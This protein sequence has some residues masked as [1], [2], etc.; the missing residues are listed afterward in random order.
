[1]LPAPSPQ[2]AKPPSTGSELNVTIIGLDNVD[3]HINWPGLPDWVSAI[4][5]ALLGPIQ[6]FLINVIFVPI[7]NRLFGN[8]TFG[9]YNISPIHVPLGP[10]FTITVASVQTQELNPTGGNALLVAHGTPAI[11]SP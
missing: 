4:I 8:F 2:P 1:V 10:G 5:D 3:L 7:I 11:S 9:I 6:D